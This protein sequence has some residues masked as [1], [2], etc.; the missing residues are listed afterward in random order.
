[1]GWAGLGWPSLL[2][3]SRRQQ[4]HPR[5]RRYRYYSQ[6]VSHERRRLIPPRCPSAD[7]LPCRRV[8]VSAQAHTY[9]SPALPALSRVTTYD[10][11]WYG[12]QEPP[13]CWIGW[14]KL[15][16]NR[17][18]ARAGERLNFRDAVTAAASPP[19]TAEPNLPVDV[20]G[21]ITTG[22]TQLKRARARTLPRTVGRGPAAVSCT[23][24]AA[25][26]AEHAARARARAR[27][28]CLVAPPVRA[29]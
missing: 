10:T 16:R 1:M 12:W 7:P 9:T 23:P 3:R 13:R 20:P 22:M 5:L 17:G 25:G 15:K 21:G 26:E 27:Q 8:L 6:E 11:G 28:A 4:Q 14:T 19:L 24:A 29:P 18:G 2:P